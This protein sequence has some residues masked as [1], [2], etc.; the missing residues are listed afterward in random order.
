MS[1]V[2]SLWQ[3]HWSWLCSYRFKLKIKLIAN[4]LFLPLWLRYNKMETCITPNNGNNEI[5]QRPVLL[6]NAFT[7]ALESLQ[8]FCLLTALNMSSGKTCP[9]FFTGKHQGMTLFTPMQS[10]S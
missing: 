9:L 1:N 3:L 7:A 2:F 4:P 8:H 5:L 10:C 6:Q